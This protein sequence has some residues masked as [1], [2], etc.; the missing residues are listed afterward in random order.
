VK[1]LSR[2]L[3]R[4]PVAWVDVHG[5][6][7]EKTL[8][9]LGELFGLHRLA[10]EDVVNVV[11]RPKVEDFG[12]H[13][14]VV[15][16]MLTRSDTLVSEQVSLFLGDRWALTFQEWPGDYLEPVRKRIRDG[17]PRLLNSGADYLTY[18]LL[19]AIVDSYFPLME[20]YGERLDALQDK[21]MEEAR[22]ELNREIY[23]IRR[24]LVGVRRAIWP[25][26]EVFSSMM[27]ESTPLITDNTRTYLRDCH[28]H[29]VQAMDLIEASREMAGSLRDV[30]LSSVGNRMNEI[31]KVLTIFAAIF[32]PLTFIAGIYGMNFN[33][34][35]SRWNM[36]EL[37]WV[38]G[39]PFALG[40][41]AA[42]AI[43][44]IFYFRRKGWF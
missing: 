22:P 16:R 6:G 1:D 39:Y 17:R 9:E 11:Q 29:T 33:P 24:E 40:L 34:E 26:R 21:V 13:L 12:A 5:L 36:P 19:D 10:L 14:Y 2:L 20:D 27:R 3:E 38:W 43:A 42:V 35:V 8:L 4:W 44:M 37:N 31:M 23:E 18:A 28:D 30:Y 7:D 25:L 15:I 32:I 41:M